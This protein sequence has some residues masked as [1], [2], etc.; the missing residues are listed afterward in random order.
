LDAAVVVADAKGRRKMPLAAYLASQ[1][2]R[3][4]ILVE[5]I[6]PVVKATRAGWSFQKLGRTQLDISLVN[7][8]VGLQVDRPGRVVFARIA[9]GAVAPTV[10]RAVAA[11]SALLGSHLDRIA[12][13]AAA[14]LVT[15]AVNPIS[16]VR[17]SAEYRREMAVVLVRRALEECALEAGCTL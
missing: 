17:A 7:A 3:P 12:V 13:A 2:Q 4:H 9:V 16:D 1:T 5:V 11:E 15:E 14:D 6:V 10:I 8:A